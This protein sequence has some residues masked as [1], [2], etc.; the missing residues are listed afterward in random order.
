[1]SDWGGV[2]L[3]G[4]AVALSTLACYLS[5]NSASAKAKRLGARLPPGPPKAVLV[6]NLFNFPNGRWY[7]TFSEWAKEYGDVVH[8]DLAGV[9]MIIL[10]SLEAIQELAEKRMIHAGRPYS[11]MVCDLMMEGFTMVLSQPGPDFKEQRRI[12]HGSIGPQAI[13]EYDSLI[14]Q[15]SLELL[16]ALS[17]FE[18]DV[19]PLLMRVVGGILTTIAYG[20]KI[21]QDHG[22]RLVAINTENIGL[23]AYAFTQIWSVDI[24]P[25]LRYLPT[26]IPGFTFPKIGARA[27]YLASQIRYWSFGA[28]KKAVAEGSADDSLVSRY[29]ANPIVSEDNLRDAVAVMW[30]AGADTTVTSIVNFLF[31]IVVFPEWQIKIQ[32][33]IDEVVGHDQVPNINNISKLKIF[34]AVWKESFRW[35]ASVPLGVPH[36]STQEDVWNGYY[37]PKQ[38]ILH[39]N[40][41]CVP[42]DVLHEFKPLRFHPDFNP[43]LDKLPDIMSIPFGF[44]RRICPG[45]FLAE[46]I[47]RQ[48]VAAILS[49]YTVTPLE[50]EEVTADMQFVDAAIRRPADFRCRFIPRYS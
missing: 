42:K 25:P 32:E 44:G 30:G 33:E 11:T 29:L 19:F 14:L 47:S 28:V 7:E 1:M 8:V 6:G 9:H 10:N 18:G 36:M 49:K 17:K 23:I 26:W 3:A 24:F 16:E 20:E 50:G 38:T 27:Y 46:R 37:I 34:N 35:N 21:Y 48:I 39:C 40:I 2:Y 5:S 45:R 22:E 41:G 43:N 4:G 15:R 12:F 31:S 13:K